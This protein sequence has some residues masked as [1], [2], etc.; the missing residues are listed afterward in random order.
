MYERQVVL[1]VFRKQTQACR[2]FHYLPK[3][4]RKSV[5]YGIS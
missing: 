5:Y 1:H 4:I 2:D 3:E